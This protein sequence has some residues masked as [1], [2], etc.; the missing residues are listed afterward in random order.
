MG[1]RAEGWCRRQFE[2]RPIYGQAGD[3]PTSSE[4]D[5]VI[6]GEVAS[7]LFRSSRRRTL[8]TQPEAAPPDVAPF[9]STIAD[10]AESKAADGFDELVLIG[11]FEFE[12][13]PRV[14]AWAMTKGTRSP[15]MVRLEPLAAFEAMREAFVSAGQP[16]WT[17]AKV[18]V[19]AD[20]EA[21]ADFTYD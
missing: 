5:H 13:S 6:D 8:M 19:T 14:R 10:V 18:T 7:A 20:G 12:D 3:R 1:P 16:L 21:T 17:Q 15:L 4:V 9:V 11:D 2:I